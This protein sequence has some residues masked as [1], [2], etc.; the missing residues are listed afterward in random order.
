MASSSASR[1]V[2]GGYTV[3]AEMTWRPRSFLSK[4]PSM[5]PGKSRIWVSARR[6]RHL[7]LGGGFGD[8]GEHGGFS[9]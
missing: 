5:I 6:I 8:F 2:R 3:I 4:A 7:G 1:R 9:D